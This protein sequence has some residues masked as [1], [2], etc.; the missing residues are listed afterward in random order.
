MTEYLKIGS[1]MPKVPL[2]FQCVFGCKYERGEN[3]GGEEGREI[4]G[5]C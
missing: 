3:E 4:F 5:G 2:A 1:G